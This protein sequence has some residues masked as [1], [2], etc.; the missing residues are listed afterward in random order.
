[1]NIG[2]SVSLC[3]FLVVDLGKPVVGSDSARVAEDKSADGIC[4]GGV[5]LNTPVV[6]VKIVVNDLLIVKNGSV[7]VSDFFSL[8]TIKNVSLGNIVVACL[9]IFLD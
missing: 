1:M 5:F 4:D 3:D 9:D 6:Y 2:V 8:L 7:D